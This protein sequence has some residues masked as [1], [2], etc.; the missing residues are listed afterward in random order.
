MGQTG[1]KDGIPR[2]EVRWDGDAG[3]AHDG[4]DTDHQFVEIDGGWIDWAREDDVDDLSEIGADHLAGK[5]PDVCWVDGRA[6]VFSMSRD[7]VGGTARLRSPVW[8][9]QL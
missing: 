5:D 6:R 2:F 4:F 8:N 3:I 9:D 7:W 1:R